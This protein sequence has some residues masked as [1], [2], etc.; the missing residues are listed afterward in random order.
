MW[1]IAYA[2]QYAIGPKPCKDQIL[3]GCVCGSNGAAT[4]KAAVEEGYR[5]IWSP[6]SSW[7]LSCYA[8]QCASSG[9]G[10]GFEPWEHVF[11][12]EP[13]LCRGASAQG[14]GR[15]R[16]DVSITDPEHQERRVMHRGLIYD[17]CTT[18]PTF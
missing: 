14:C 3:G 11:A 10:A 18:D 13:F 2:N 7:Y 5:A 1:L 8:D 6:P 9:N 4:T 12:Q 17:S 15:G 16:S